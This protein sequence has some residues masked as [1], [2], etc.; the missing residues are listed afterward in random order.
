V[1]ST[2]RLSGLS[3]ELDGVICKGSDLGRGY[4]WRGLAARTGV[5]YEAARDLPGLRALGAVPARDVMP[6]EAAAVPPVREAAA[7][8][9]PPVTAA[10]GPAPLPLAPR[11][12]DAPGA[13]LRA[14][15]PDDVPVEVFDL[16]RRRCAAEWP[17]HYSMRVYCEKQQVEGYRELKGRLLAP[18]HRPAAARR[19]RPRGAGRADAARLRRPARR[20]GRAGAGQ[21]GEHGAA[22]GAELRGRGRP[23]ARV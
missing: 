12:V 23:A 4:S 21:P 3:F 5:T 6:H 11:G 15:R 1:A 18:R 20:G 19:D 13:K 9:R 2:E 8:D 14:G 22:V 16:M 7:P 17:T 10:V